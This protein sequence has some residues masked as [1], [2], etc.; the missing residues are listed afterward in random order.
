MHTPSTVAHV[1]AIFRY[2]PIFFTAM[3]HISFD[4][5]DVLELRG[6]RASLLVA[7]QFGAR[8]L[9]WVVDGQPVIY[10]P[11]HADW[12]A[13]ARIRGGNPVLFPFIGRHFVDGELGAWRDRQ[14]EIRAMPMHGF[15]RDL[16]FAYQ[17]EDQAQAVRMSL[18]DTPQ[19]RAVYP[20]GFRFETYYR[21]DSNALEVE[22]ITH[23]TGD[24]PLPY[25]AGHHFYFAL[26]AELRAD[27]V[28]SLPRNR[29][30]FQ[31]ADGSPAPA[32]HG[33]EHYRLD[34]PEIMDRFHVLEESG[35]VTIQTPALGRTITLSLN[36]DQ[37]DSV[38]WYAVTTWT[39][40][41]DADFYCVEPWL[42][43][44]DAIHHGQGLRWIAPGQ[45]ERAALRITV[46]TTTPKR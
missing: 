13:P 8:L 27:T 15:A 35:D 39:E 45:R 20:F 6:P 1:S 9:R 25:Y 12:S 24:E 14:G 4:Q 3:T 29:R 23:N 31:S 44:P 17:L 30:Q 33:Q 19:T 37:S 18:S 40:R 10:W 32:I 5:Q 11:E 7:P 36:S 38:P 22:F 2:L 41:P 43:L 21:L 26:P 46:E 16:P 42:G 34:D 28:L